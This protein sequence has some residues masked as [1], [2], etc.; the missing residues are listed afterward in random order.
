MI[1]AVILAAGTG[2]RFGGVKPLAALDGHPLI[3]HVI[4]AARAAGV[5]HAVVVVGY[6]AGKV[7]AHLHDLDVEIVV[8]PDYARG[9]AGSVRVGIDALMSRSEIEVAV[10]LLADQPR[11]DPEVIRRVV[12][13]LDGGGDLARARYDDG[14]GHPVAIPRRTWPLVRQRLKGDAG[15]R[16]LFGELDIVEVPVAGPMPLDVDRPE[17]LDALR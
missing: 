8:N 3:D 14:G 11:I 4:E 12:A 5:D 17:D 16:Q 15:A 2:S 9:Q 6:E 10:M 7:T 1:A 13:V